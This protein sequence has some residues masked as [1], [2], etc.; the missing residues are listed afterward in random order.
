[1]PPDPIL[2]SIL[3][4]PFSVVPIKG[5]LDGLL[6]GLVPLPRRRVP[7]PLEFAGGVAGSLF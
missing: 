6:E 4:L 5:L 3:Y 7:L 1:M 2:P